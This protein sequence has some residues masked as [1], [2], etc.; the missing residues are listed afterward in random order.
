MLGEPL[1]ALLIALL[2]LGCTPEGDV[3][4]FA[5]AS[6]RVAL[7]DAVAGWPGVVGGPH[8]LAALRHGR[9][10]RPGPRALRRAGREGERARCYGPDG[11][12]AA[13]LEGSAIPGAWHP[14]RVFSG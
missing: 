6:L 7:E 4:V 3:V 10:L 11:R 8:A 14:Y 2:A 5:A 13:L 1:R 9:D 12:L